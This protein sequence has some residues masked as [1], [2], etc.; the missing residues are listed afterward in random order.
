MVVPVIFL[1]VLVLMKFYIK[2][3]LRLKIGQLIKKDGPDLHGYKEG[4]P[5]M[6][7]LVFM[8]VSLLFMFFLKVHLFI[9]LST[10]FFMLLGLVD[11]LTGILKKDAY[12]MKARDKFLLQVILAFV[13]VALFFN[14][15]TSINLFD[16]DSW[17]V[18]RAGYIIFA[19]LVLVASTNAVN[20]TDGLDGL[21]G[22][23]VSTSLV[24]IY[25]YLSNRGISEKSVFV[26]LPAISAFLIFNSKPAK[27]FMGDTGSL[28]LGAYLGSLA[29]YYRFEMLLLF[30][31]SIVVVE[32]I[33]VILQVL[34]FKIRKKRIFKMAPIHHH[35][36]LLGW[37]ESKIVAVF[38]IINFVVGLSALGVLS[39]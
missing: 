32:T 14:T 21:A 29:V 9:I 10:L 39:L 37:E 8:G 35:L 16:I 15:R 26:I 18:G 11:D 24:V 22:T 4:T 36:E 25:V 3:M 30:F 2:Y 34:S 12:A 5:T 13:L 31:S 17:A 1:L 6:G 33:S 28:A 27:V 20:L 38:S 23:V 7:G 19:T